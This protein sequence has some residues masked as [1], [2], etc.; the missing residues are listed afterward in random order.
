MNDT[1]EMTWCYL[2]TNKLE[3]RNVDFALIWIV[4]TVCIS[5]IIIV[6]TTGSVSLC[7]FSVEG[8]GFHLVDIMRRREENL[9][10]L[11]KRRSVSMCFK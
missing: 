8:V 2:M 6:T 1:E 9:F 3:K 10:G 7:F 5:E 4:N 11:A